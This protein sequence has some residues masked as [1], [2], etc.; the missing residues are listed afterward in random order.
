MLYDVAEAA[1]SEPFVFY[2]V[3]GADDRDVG[4]GR[5]LEVVECTEGVLGLHGED[6]DITIAVGDLARMADNSDGDVDFGFGRAEVET[7]VADGG[8]VFAAADEDDVFAGE[9][10]SRADG[11]ADGTCSVD[12]VSH[13][14]Y[15]ADRSSANATTDQWPRHDAGCATGGSVPIV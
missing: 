14:T 9:G 6:N 15:L 13:V 12:D 7:A 5:G 3:L 8:E 4:T 1:C 11:P 2:A 10:E